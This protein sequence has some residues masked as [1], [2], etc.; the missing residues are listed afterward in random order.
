MANEK[1]VLGTA[2]S[3]E[4]FNDY[5]FSPVPDEKKNTWKSQIFVWLGVGFCLTAFTLGGQIA[6]GLGFW[7]TVAAVFIGGIILTLVG[8][9]CGAIG[10]RSG[11]SSTVSS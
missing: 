8:I 2:E 6:L 3:T 11:L 5:E 4:V 9:L 10:V 1:N 7:P